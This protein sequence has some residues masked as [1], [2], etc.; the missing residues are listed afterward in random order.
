MGWA[1][2][3]YYFIPSVSPWLNKNKYMAAMNYFLIN[4]RASE[5]KKYKLQSTKIVQKNSTFSV[6]LHDK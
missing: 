2:K 1:F 3:F 6:G 4:L 5:S